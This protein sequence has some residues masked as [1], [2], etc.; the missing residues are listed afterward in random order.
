MVTYYFCFQILS[1]PS[2]PIE[3]QWACG[4]PWFDSDIEE[5][6]PASPQQLK[7]KSRPSK[8][9]SMDQDATTS[10]VSSKIRRKGHRLV[11]IEVI[12]LNRDSSDSESVILK[13]Q[14]VVI[15]HINEIVDMTEK[16][17]NKV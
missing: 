17:I 4:Q 2:M 1:D 9:R 6:R 7:K 15:T 3:T 16:I 12:D 13:A 10:F 8:K 14:Y 11:R 5:V